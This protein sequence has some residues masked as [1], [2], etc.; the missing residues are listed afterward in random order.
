V[1]GFLEG[2][3]LTVVF[4]YGSLRPRLALEHIETFLASHG[5]P[6][7]G[8]KLDGDPPVSLAQALERLE[9]THSKHFTLV[10]QGFQFNLS[11]LARWKLDFLGVQLMSKPGRVWDEWAG[12]FSKLPDFVMAWVADREYEYWQNASDPLSYNVLGKSYAGLPTM[13]NGLAYPLEQQVIDTSRNPG[14]RIL[15]EGYIEVVG[16]V[17]W[18]GEPF[19]QLSWADREQVMAAEWLRISNPAPSVTRLEA[20]ERCFT[21]EEDGSAALQAKLRALL[22]PARNGA[23]GGPLHH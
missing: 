8:F 13:S 17:M 19:W 9:A 10:G 7:V 6:R 16:A 12:P 14:R 20:A 5:V 15:R 22:F 21:T 2:E 3:R 18:L 1:V 4:K 11:S 23:P